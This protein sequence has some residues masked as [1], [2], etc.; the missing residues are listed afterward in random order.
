MVFPPRL[1][2]ADEAA[3]IIKKVEDNLNGRS[4][5]L[6]I[7]MIIKTSRATRTM[8]MES[9]SVGSEKSFIKITYPGKDY[10]ITFLK[11]ND[12]MWQYVPRI[13]K[14]IK[15]PASMML[16]SWM[17][18]D[19]SNDDLVRESS[20]SRDYTAKILSQSDTAYEIELL[21]QPE[22]AVVWGKLVMGVAKP[23][24]LPQ[25]VRYYDEEGVLVRILEYTEVKRLG[26]RLYPSRWVMLPQDKEKYGN[27]TIIEITEATFDV[28]IDEEYFSK[29]AL[30]R[31]SE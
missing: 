21:P 27:Q 19:F 13:E 28:E 22:A 10:G 26:D 8:K 3:E 6:K 5:V 18:T 30:Q 24:L 29:R 23:E 25:S 15:I 1:A 31:F 9:F 17:G 2:R 20:I 12:A 16:Q 7:A 14:I 4:A 11:I